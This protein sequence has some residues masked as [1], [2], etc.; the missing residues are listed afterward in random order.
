VRGGVLRIRA[1]CAWTLPGPCQ[2]SYRVEVGPGVAVSALSVG[3]DVRVAGIRGDVG[4]ETKAGDVDLVGLRSS[5]VR[6]A[7]T[8]GN[9]LADLRKAPERVAVRSTAGDVHI[10]LPRG[11][12]AVDADT[13]AGEDSVS[14]VVDDP[15]AQRIV[16][17]R[18][19]AGNAR[20]EGR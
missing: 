16:T 12:Y 11:T 13:T 7:T 20:V 15:E 10:R 3:G 2:T 9:V 5:V 18:T 6:A 17:A 1:R 14:G 19:T 4:V 8:A